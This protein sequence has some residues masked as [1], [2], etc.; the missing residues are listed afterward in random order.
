MTLPT[1][2]EDQ[3]LFVDY[4]R[5][6]GLKHTAIPNSTYTTSITQKMKNQRSGLCAGFPDLVV[7]VGDTLVIIEMKR[8]KRSVLSPE[9]ASWIAELAKCKRIVVG[10]AK[11]DEEAIAIIESV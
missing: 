2:Y 6:R 3:V 1:E 9:Q 4:L 11:G 7:I 5:R 8:R 10:I